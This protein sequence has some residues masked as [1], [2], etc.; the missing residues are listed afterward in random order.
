MLD[1]ATDQADRGDEV[2]LQFVRRSALF[3]P[4]DI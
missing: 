1:E 2:L 4:C 3:E